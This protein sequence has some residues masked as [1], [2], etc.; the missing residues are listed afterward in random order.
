MGRD[1]AGRRVRRL[2][3]AV[4]T[5]SD[6]SALVFAVAILRPAP[7]SEIHEPHPPQQPPSNAEK[8]LMAEIC[9]EMKQKLK[10]EA[11]KPGSC[12]SHPLHVDM[13]LG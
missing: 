4:I 12:P 1:T 6:S 8:K 13:R 3:A 9:R 10:V 11:E 2:L 5:R 7:Y